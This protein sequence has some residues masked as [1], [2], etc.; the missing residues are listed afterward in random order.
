MAEMLEQKNRLAYD[1]GR[2]QTKVDHLQ[3]ELESL[4]N[5]QIELM[6]L[7]KNNQTLEAKYSK[8]STGTDFTGGH[9]IISF[10]EQFSWTSK[11]IDP[12]KQLGSSI[13]KCIHNA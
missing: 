9:Y 4:A 1:K 12:C 13:E 8:V 7:R 2:L 10:L 11:S 3:S 6:Q 5:S